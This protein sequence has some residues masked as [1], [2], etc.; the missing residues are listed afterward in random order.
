MVVKPSRRRVAGAYIRTGWASRRAAAPLLLAQRDCQGRGRRVAVPARTREG[1]ACPRRTTRLG[2]ARRRDGLHSEP[3]RGA[4]LRL[5]AT[6]PVRATASTQLIGRRWCA[7][8]V[9]HTPELGPVAYTLRVSPGS[10]SG[11][12]PLRSSAVTATFNPTD[13]PVSLILGAC[14]AL[15]A[16]CG[17][18]IGSAT[19]ASSCSASCAATTSVSTTA[20]PPT[21]LSSSSGSS[22]ATIPATN[23]PH[24]DVAGFGATTAAWGPATRYDQRSSAGTVFTLHLPGVLAWPEDGRC[25]ISFTPPGEARA[26]RSA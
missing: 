2:C 17:S 12:R 7:G 11:V 3:K 19:S 16:G 25:S 23:A 5:G 15:I 20:P 6:C 9:E 1:S 13:E 22:A 24:T 4:P 18:S 21:P 14:T 26:T 10:A 8:E